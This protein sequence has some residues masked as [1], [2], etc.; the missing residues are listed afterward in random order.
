MTLLAALAVLA[1]VTLAFVVSASAGL[2]GSLVLVPVLV[3]AMG[4]KEGVATAALLLAANNIVKVIAYR[5]TLP[6]RASGLVVLLT[7]VGAGVGAAALV[8]APPALVR[9]GVAVS[10]AGSLVAE[11]AHALRIQRAATPVLALAAGAT[12][13]FSGTSGPLKGVA[14]KELRLDAAH[15][16]G[17]ASLVS[18][19]ADVVKASVFA[20]ASLLGPDA[21][22]LTVV[23]VPLMLIGTT[24]GWR[25]NTRLGERGYAVLFWSVMS[26]YT[27][28]LLLS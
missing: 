28:R 26:G 18:L 13:G 23:S 4:V 21:W 19:T 24:L 8:A 17:A 22:R 11:R 3:L 10:I 2:G 12:S 14:V 15:T 9:L 1:A 25:L 16:A 20:E 27:V 7:M 5:R 6:V